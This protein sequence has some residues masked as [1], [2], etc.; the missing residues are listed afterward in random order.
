MRLAMTVAPP[1]LSR[2]PWDWLKSHLFNSWGNGLL[3]L[4]LLSLVVWGGWSIAVWG[5][6]I[7]DWSVV[8]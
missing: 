1:V 5:F 6:T 8:S 4:G 7:A 3:S 2:S